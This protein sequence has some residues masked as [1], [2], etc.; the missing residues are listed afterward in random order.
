MAKP[1]HQA[2]IGVS[3]AQTLIR[4]G[5][6]PL[7]AESVSLPQ[8]LDRVLAETV[9]AG[10]NLPPFDNS[11]MDG[12]AVC[13]KD[14][15]D[16]LPAEGLKLSLSGDVPAGATSRIPLKPG[17]AVRI[18][19]GA[20]IPPGADAVIPVERTT[21]AG[22]AGTALPA[23]VVLLE[24]PRPGA[25]IR[26]SGGDVRAGEI[27]L[28]AGRR[29]RPADLGMLAALGREVIRVY[30]RP[31]VA[32]F[33]TGDELVRLGSPLENGKIHDSNSYMLQGLLRHCGCTP[34]PLE[35]APDRLEA[36]VERLDLAVSQRADVILTSAGV[37]VGAYDYVRR[38][39]EQN[40]EIHL[41]RVNIRPGKP[42]AYGHYRR[43]PFFGLPGNP[44]SAW[45]TFELFV[46]P[47]LERMQGLTESIQMR[48]RA[49]MDQAV[50]SDGRQS[51]FRALVRYG[52]HGY[53][54][55]LT[56]SQD[57]GVLSSLLQANALV[58]LPAGVASL[59][60]GDEAEAW[61]MDAIPWPDSRPGGA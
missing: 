34:L 59:K 1:L 18:T 28:K 22:E 16:V 8:A 48:V 17:T 32:L 39:V 15:P 40:G 45:V 56:G 3:Q 9:E 44:V 29:L 38:A 5:I 19:T 24:I 20:P 43:L 50:E 61:L 60:A 25:H 41:W 37:S 58:V 57:S 6:E 36:V 30:R 33:S 2:P 26:P 12:F 21:Y 10:Y 31:R 51:Y 11:A 7:A 23:H 27:V 4:E 49:I 42:V 55:A 52:P 47:L 46:C 53:H 14:L 54:A 35:A 13:R